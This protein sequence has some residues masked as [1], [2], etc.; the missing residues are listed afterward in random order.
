M[1]H[2]RAR[3]AAL[4]AAAVLDT[5]PEPAFD[6]IATLAR[7]ALH[8]AAAFVSL[9]SADRQYL[10]SCVI[11]SG[12]A[13]EGASAPIALSFCRSVVETMAPLRVDDTRHDPA[14]R[15]HPGTHAFGIGAYLGA[16][17]VVEGGHGL[18]SLCVTEPRAR[19]W[20]E[21]DVSV[22]VG[23]AA[24]V[25]REFE[26]RA[27]N[28]RLAE[29]EAALVAAVRERDAVFA[30]M[31]DAVFVFDREGTYVQVMPTA[32]ELLYRPG[33]ELVGRRVHDVLPTAM[34]DVFVGCVRR[35]LDEGRAVHHDYS[36][37]LPGRPD[38]PARLTHFHATA[39][40]LDAAAGTVVWV[41]RDVTAHREAED[42]VRASEARLR[43]MNVA[44][45]VG[46]F[47]ADLEGRVRHVNPRCAE[48]WGVTEAELLGDAWQARV[49]VHDRGPLLA[50]WRA[51][52]ARGVEFA[53]VYRLVMLDADGGAP[54]VR[55]VHGRTAPLRDDAGRV[56]GSVGTIEDVTD[57][58]QVET[59]QRR[60]TGILEAM[61]DVVTVA[62][63]CG[64]IEYLNAAGR[65]LLGVRGGPDAVQAARL[66][67]ATLQPQFAPDGPRA[68]AVAAA[69]LDGSWHGE[70]TLTRC[71]GREIPVDQLILSH[72][73]AN[74]DIEYLS[75]VLR[76]VTERKQADATLRAFALV[77][78]LTGLYNRR[79][80][81]ALAE[82][83]WEAA[84]AA[85]QAGVCVYLDLDDF[86]QVN[87]THGHAEGDRA[88]AAVAGVLRRAFR[89]SDVVGRI[90]GDEFV[91]FARCGVGPGCS[92]A[93]DGA[94]A[95]AARLQ[96][97]I[98]ALLAEANLAAGRP[99]GLAASVGVAL[100]D[101]AASTTLSALMMAADAALYDR[102]RAR[103]RVGMAA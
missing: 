39:S 84:Q 25:G 100:F 17:I 63:P 96:G 68:G 70:T 76:D 12:P 80:F 11:A 74:G 93:L 75:S 94:R 62:A 43:A 38:R 73:G 71:D 1:L 55:W 57:R 13:A 88:L 6:R 82:R 66:H 59:T 85:G 29:R 97:R 22:L 10:K 81:L 77:D 15:D 50:D 21:Q 23:L 3:L 40:P 18:G 46:V 102:K 101:P 90:G 89:D 14:W 86:K 33:D 35:A 30:A 34:A 103:G 45:P 87:D 47:E 37:E 42:A 60:L 5:P 24:A 78:E 65:R 28:R 19:A 56:V 72:R 53:R 58:Q 36:L 98:Q 69:M 2:D 51:A 99:Y 48:I 16:P 44:S 4:E 54:R 61:P 67:V 95:T 31:H 20:T 27:A 64:R 41:A 79:G 9:V 52:A 49:H 32:P 91:A 8:A 92:S 26:L 83:E 7:E